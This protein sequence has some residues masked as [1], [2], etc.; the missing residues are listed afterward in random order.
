LEIGLSEPD[1]KA[2]TAASLMGLQ[3]NTPISLL[4]GNAR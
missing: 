4:F 2:N 1:T 3:A